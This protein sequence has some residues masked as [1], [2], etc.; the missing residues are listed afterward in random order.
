MTRALIVDDDAS[1]L[2]MLRTL[3]EGNGYSVDQAHHGAEALV[4]AR[5][6]PPDIIVSDLLMPVLDGYALLRHWRSDERLSS[7]PFIVY[8]ATYTEPRDERLAMALGA[9]AFIIKP[10]EPE[11]LMTRIREVVTRLVGKSMP[12]RG[13]PR[14]DDELLLTEYNAV[15]FGKLEKKALQL[16]QSNRQLLEEIAERKRTE[17]ALRASEERFRATF[18]RAAVGIAHMNAA[19]KFLRVNDKLCE[20]TGYSRDELLQLSFAELN[21]HADRSP[22]DDTFR[23]VLTGARKVS[24]AEAR[25]L[26]K[27]GATFWASSI[28]SVVQDDPDVPG[29]FIFVMID[30]TDR[31]ALE[32]Q[33]RQSQKLEAIGRLAGG[34]AHDFN[35][36]LTIVSGYCEMILTTPGLQP[37]L[38]ES[39]EAIRDAGERAS[40]LTRQLLGFSRQTILQPQVLDLNLAIH[41]SAKLLRRLLGEDISLTTALAPDL[42]RV[43]VDPSHLDQVLINLAINARDA[44]PRGGRIAV[45]T[46]N[47]MLD[48]TATGTHLDCK[49]GSYVR[50]VLTDTGCGMTQAVMARIFEPFFTTKEPG[51]GTG[52]GLAMVFGIVRQSGG[53]IEVDSKPGHGTT[54]RIYL[55]AADASSPAMAVPGLH[56]DAHGTETILFVEDD[57]GVR[58]QAVTSLGKQGYRVLAATDGND[59]LTIARAQA[60][61]PDL[62]LT[63]IVM[64][65]LGGAE[66]ARRIRAQFPQIKVMFMS[67]HA[68]DAVVRHGLLDAGVAF[69]QKP[70]TPTTLAQKVRQVLDESAVRDE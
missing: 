27:N 19:G 58:K 44:M 33:L 69:I 22:N 30:I 31:K 11:P 68:D 35:N 63:D 2:Y 45:E 50:L 61:A 37:D 53:W 26:R 8:T 38:R 25:Y 36:L 34:I 52:L 39:A 49:P 29:Y 57:A 6:N 28:L 41:E 42:S 15:L 12:L 3:L 60:E 40:A 56:E 70:Y 24:S 64:P 51:K 48:S 4:K 7:I 65:N 23:A 59:A 62:L 10:A 16:E 20:I 13:A 54:F 67:G 17:S 1:N 18:E 46:D 66:L 14:P 55:P 5:Q 47:V 43:K 9:D 21:T 32:D